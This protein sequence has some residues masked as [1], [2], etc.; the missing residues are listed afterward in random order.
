[1]DVNEEINTSQ[2]KRDG[3]AQL[4]FQTKTQINLDAHLLI[5]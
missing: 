3:D 1:M 4:Y 5:V 2:I